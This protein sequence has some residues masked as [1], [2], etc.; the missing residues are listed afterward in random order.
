MTSMACWAGE[1]NKLVGPIVKKLKKAISASSAHI[2]WVASLEFSELYLCCCPCSIIICQYRY[3]NA[4]H[5]PSQT[6][7]TNYSPNQI[8]YCEMYKL[9]LIRNDQVG[10]CTNLPI[11]LE[12]S[13]RVLLFLSF[14]LMSEWNE[15]YHNNINSLDRDWPELYGRWMPTSRLFYFN[16]TVGSRGGGRMRVCPA[17]VVNYENREITEFGD[18]VFGRQPYV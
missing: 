18:H 2:S 11:K 1:I 17:W 8:L 13:W 5:C 14:S 16:R 9:R 12:F 15:R 3:Q 7:V 4:L 10:E 6:L